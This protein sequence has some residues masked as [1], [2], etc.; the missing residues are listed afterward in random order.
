MTVRWRYFKDATYEP[1]W[2]NFVKFVSGGGIVDRDYIDA[3]LEP[4]NARRVFLEGK[5]DVIFRSRED[6]VWFLLRW[7]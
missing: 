5:N 2:L 4:F 7:S 1:A 6:L 3:A